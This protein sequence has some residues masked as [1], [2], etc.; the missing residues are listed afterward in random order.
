LPAAAIAA[1]HLFRLRVELSWLLF[2]Y[3]LAPSVGASSTLFSLCTA[4]KIG[5]LPKRYRF[6]SSLGIGGPLGQ[7][8]VC[9]CGA[10]GGFCLGGDGVR[11]AALAD[12]ADLDAY[13]TR[14]FLPWRREGEVLIVACADPSAEN[15]GWLTAHYGAVRVTLIA[16]SD[17]LALLGAQFG[18]RLSDDAIYGLSRAR[19]DLSAHHVL[20]KRQALVFSVMG[21]ASLTLLCF[22]P[23]AMALCLVSG[24]AIAFFVSALFRGC[25][26]WFGTRTPPPVPVPRSEDVLLPLYTILAPLYREANVLPALARALLALDYPLDRLDIKLVVEADDEKT[27]HAARK[28]AEEHAVFQVIV[29]PPSLPRTKPKAANYALRYARGDFLVIYDA[30]DRPEPDQ[31]RK[32]VAAFRSGPRDLACLQARLNFYN[33]DGWLTKMFALDYALWFDFLM[34]GLDHIAVPMPLGGTSNHFRTA[35]LRDIG[36][37][38]AFNVTEDADIG[39]RLSQ[40][41]HR[42]SMLDSTTF[43]EAPSAIGAWLRQR[44]RWLKGYMQTWLVHTRSPLRLMRRTGWRGLFAFQL[45]IG[46]AL[47]CALINPLLWAIFI[48]AALFHWPL[49]SGPGR[50]VFVYVSAGGLVGTNFLLTGLAMIGPR[51][52]GWNELSPYGLTVLL[53]WALVSMAG[54]RALWQLATNPFFWEKTAHGSGAELQ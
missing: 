31:L 27:L 12:V 41:G 3:N 16:R 34:P 40:L 20:T 42:V 35:V 24:M 39:M 22:H 1:E 37:W 25:L 45:F 13:L 28:V 5:V 30:E 4:L 52:R 49:F 33:I 51:R 19:P 36:G 6:D 17:M 9:P 23:L 14:L 26:A 11:D 53:Y 38:D 46:G 21:G 18:A 32:A 54:Y 15:Y 7:D 2:S 43:E 8:I 44:S 29:V 47:S 48:A 50:H 10:P